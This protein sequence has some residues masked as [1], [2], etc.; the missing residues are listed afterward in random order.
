MIL[1]FKDMPH[2]MTRCQQTLPEFC[3][4]T[5]LQIVARFV[6]DFTDDTSVQRAYIC[7]FFLL[8]SLLSSKN[9][10]FGL[11]TTDFYIKLFALMRSCRNTVNPEDEELNK[12]SM[13]YY[14]VKCKKICFHFT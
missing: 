1:V 6:L 12:A 5:A 11:L 9:G 2:L 13:L 10:N 8:N 4:Q 14:Q 7:L 3:V